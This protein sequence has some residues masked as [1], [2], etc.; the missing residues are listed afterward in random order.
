MKSKILAAIAVVVL[1]VGFASFSFAGTAAADSVTATA[2]EVPAASAPVVPATTASSTDGPTVSLGGHIKMTIFDR[3]VTI[4][5]NSGAQTGIAHSYGLAFRELDLFIS[6]RIND[7]ISFEVDPRFSASS[8]ATPKLG[9]TT[10]A[11][12]GT[13]YAFGAF[14]HGKACL[15][16][17]LPYDVNIEVGQLHPKFTAE[18][19]SELF[20]EEQF[21]GGKFAAN[22]NVGALH[23]SGIEASKS[24]DVGDITLPV[25]LYLLNGPTETGAFDINNQP[26]GMI[27]IEPVWNGLTAL[28]SIYAAKYDV[29]EDKAETRWSYGLMY[30]LGN[31]SL[32]SE[33]AYAKQEGLINGASGSNRDAKSEGYYFKA[34]Y[35]VLPWLKLYVLHESAYDNY[36]ANAATKKNDYNPVRYLGTTP[37]FD[38]YLADATM[39]QFQLDIENWRNNAGTMVLVYTRPFLGIRCTF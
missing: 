33:Y 10:T 19:G 14:G 25:Y 17:K 38:I 3:P 29:N 32:R 22:T 34:M 37:G 7:W 15:D 31:L 2:A 9:V 13:D 11:T 21:N 36:F 8:G 39:L 30:T 12:T 26:G 16:F 18:Y 4:S 23:D 27:H 1:A 6:G 20:W 5:Q 28:G 24:F 35:K